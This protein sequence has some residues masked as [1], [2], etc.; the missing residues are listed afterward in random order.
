MVAERW[1]LESGRW[2]RK[3]DL[4]V[5]VSFDGWIMD[6]TFGI[7]GRTRK[8]AIISWELGTGSKKLVNERRSLNCVRATT[9]P[10]NH[11]SWLGI[12]REFTIEKRLEPEAKPLNGGGWEL[13]SGPILVGMYSAR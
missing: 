9:K 3:F 7:K 13:G 4:E 8:L 11:C 12:N 1:G 6:I 10:F 5:E 2:E